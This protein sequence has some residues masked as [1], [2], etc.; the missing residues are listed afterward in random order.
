MAQKVISGDTCVEAKVIWWSNWKEVRRQLRKHVSLD[1]F[2]FPI[3]FSA[4]IA[5]GSTLEGQKNVVAIGTGKQIRPER[6]VQEPR[7]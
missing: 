1:A 6:P 3:I 2:Y 5:E 4:L 7:I